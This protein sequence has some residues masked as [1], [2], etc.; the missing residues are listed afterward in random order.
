[1]SLND[2]AGKVVLITGG[3]RGIGYAAAE[4]FAAR[5]ARV[6]INDLN[7]EAARESATRLGPLHLGVGGDVSSEADTQAM[8][9]AAL[10]LG[11]LDVLINNAGIADSWGPIINHPAEHWRRV[12]DVHVTGMFLLCQRAA[13]PMLKQRSGAIVSLSSIAGVVGLPR[14]PA[15]STAK[16][17][18]AM[19]TKILAVEWAAN[20][21][22][23]NAVAPGYIETP[24][25]KINVDAGNVDVRDLKAR[26]PMGE[27]GRPEDVAKA[28]AF[29]A[30]DAARYITGVTLPVDGGYTAWGGQSDAYD[31]ERAGL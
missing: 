10:S 22:R 5:R 1:M 14:R 16:A 15:Y 17:S 28:I 12:M 31:P 19:L 20:G 7:A 29:L 25:L 26:T 18:I 3:A 21:V 27:L 9:D 23:V 30:S 13:V 6:V 11:R 8:V 4:E 24:L 2:F